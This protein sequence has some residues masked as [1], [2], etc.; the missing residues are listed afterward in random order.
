MNTTGIV[1]YGQTTSFGMTQNTNDG[2]VSNH[3]VTL[4][5]L[6]KRNTYYLVIV[7]NSTSGL[8]AKSDVI[9]FATQ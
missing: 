8:T 5:S 9:T 1:S 3:S 4:N 7:A 2:A 6:S